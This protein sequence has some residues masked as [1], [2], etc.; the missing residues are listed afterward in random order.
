MQPACTGVAFYG[1]RVFVKLLLASG[2]RVVRSWI[3]FDSCSLK[4]KP[5]V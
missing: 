2:A 1:V 3:L 4:E 5:E